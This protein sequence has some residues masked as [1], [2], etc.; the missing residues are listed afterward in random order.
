MPPKKQQ[1]RDQPRSGPPNPN[2]RARGQNRDLEQ[3]TPATSDAKGKGKARPDTPS[4][5]KAVPAPAK[6]RTAAQKRKNKEDGEVAYNETLPDPFFDPIN[7]DLAIIRARKLLE[8]PAW[9][10]A[11]DLVTTPSIS[12]SADLPPSTRGVSQDQYLQP[13]TRADTSSSMS[14][15]AS[16]HRRNASPA[17]PPRQPPYRPS[18]AEARSPRRLSPSRHPPEHQLYHP[19]DADLVKAIHESHS[20]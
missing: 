12:T 19:S 18:E 14:S 11:E 10:G 1:Q 13:P 9:Q 16:K 3:Q 6:K 15:R 20:L 8:L 2:T 5:G 17:L 7:E 4:Q